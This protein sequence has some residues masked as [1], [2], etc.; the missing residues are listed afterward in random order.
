MTDDQKEKFSKN[1]FRDKNVPDEFNDDE[2]AK[3]IRDD[4]IMRHLKQFQDK[5]SQQV[6]DLSDTEEFFDMGMYNIDKEGVFNPN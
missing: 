4:K 6:V 3:R 5:A 2:I 1:L